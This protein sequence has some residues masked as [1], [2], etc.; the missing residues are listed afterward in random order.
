M[1]APL[2]VVPG[3]M[4]SSTHKAISGYTLGLLVDVFDG[5]P[6]HL[7]KSYTGRDSVRL[8][9]QTNETI[10]LKRLC[11]AKEFRDEIASG[12]AESLPQLPHPSVLAD[13][14]AAKA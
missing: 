1:K 12:R 6:L 9:H 4:T 14:I 11:T 5:Y 8:L 13:P 10:D 7:P 3:I 2:L